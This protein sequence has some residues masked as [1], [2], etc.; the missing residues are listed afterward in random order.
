MKLE[1][2]LER[3]SLM[4]QTHIN[5]FMYVV[6]IER[7]TYH[8]KEEEKKLKNKIIVILGKKLDFWRFLYIPFKIWSMYSKVRVCKYVCA[9]N[10]ASTF[11]QEKKTNL[12]HA[13]NCSNFFLFSQDEPFTAQ[14]I[15]SVFFPIGINYLLIITALL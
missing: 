3:N 14:F 12:N 11:T 10:L 13:F 6:F 4:T 1:P 7:R 9:Y 8:L 5:Q 2:P 15:S